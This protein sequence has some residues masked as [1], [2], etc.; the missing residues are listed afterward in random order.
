[1][2]AF[3]EF[4]KNAWKHVPDLRDLFI[5][6][7]SKIIYFENSITELCRAAFILL[8]KLSNFAF[9]HKCFVNPR[10]LL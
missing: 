4:S 8:N 10:K 9:A 2:I 6:F 7:E 5:Y 3:F 1:M